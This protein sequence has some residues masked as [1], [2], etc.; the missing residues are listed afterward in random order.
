MRSCSIAAFVAT[1]AVGG[2]AVLLHSNA[3]SP[4]FM[5]VAG[6]SSAE[7]NCLVETAGSVGLD[8]CSKAVAAGDGKNISNH[9]KSCC[10]RALKFCLAHR[11][12][13]L[14]SDWQR[15]VDE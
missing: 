3:S 7:E 1:F 8:A 14:V 6:V 11:S 13:D 2:D 12:R 10:G 5:L 4:Q 15:T 9:I